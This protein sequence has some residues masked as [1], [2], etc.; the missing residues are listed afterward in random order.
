MSLPDDAASS[1]LFP[2]M[3][4]AGVTSERI[5]DLKHDAV[6]ET[7]WKAFKSARNSKARGRLLR[8]ISN[9][10]YEA[11]TNDYVIT[12]EPLSNSH[13]I[14]GRIKSNHILYRTF[15]EIFYQIPVPVRSIEWLGRIREN[16]ISTA[17]SDSL[18]SQHPFTLL[19]Q[20]LFI[21]VFSLAHGSFVF[22]DRRV[23]TIYNR[24]DDFLDMDAALIG[25]VSRLAASAC[26][27]I[28][29]DV[30]GLG[31]EVLAALVSSPDIEF[32]CAQES[33]IHSSGFTRFISGAMTP[34]VVA[35]TIAAL[36]AL[37]KEGDYTNIDRR[38]SQVE[39]VNL[40]PGADPDCTRFVR[41]AT[42]RILDTIDVDT[43]IQMCEAA[44]EADKRAGLEPTAVPIPTP[45][46]LR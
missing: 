29:G 15:P 10:Y 21:E 46:P 38:K 45:R 13:V 31:K 41:E 32:T 2:R 17:L 27:A 6:A 12:P 5:G 26:A 20:S 1:E 3:L 24:L 33:D 19:G 34:L 37:S 11:S 25:N 43:A 16:K 23:A 9:F 14:V 36:V 7:N 30:E 40:L 22:K 35:C 8:S 4:A 28:A 42:K 18:R 44:K 39:I